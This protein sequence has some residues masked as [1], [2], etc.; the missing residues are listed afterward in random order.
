[1]VIGDSG[2]IKKAILAREKTNNAQEEADS[3]ISKYGNKIDEAINGIA[4][5]GGASDVI[6]CYLD[7]KIL[8]DIPKKESGYH[9]ESIT[10]TEGAEAEFNT[11][12]W[13]LTISKITN[14]NVKCTL[15][16]LASFLLTRLNM[17]EPLF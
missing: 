6:T 7:G 15:K 17:Q 3:E 4:R 13:E 16:T 9:L 10:C 14:K 2:I 12:V 11:S 8:D 1:M 5:E